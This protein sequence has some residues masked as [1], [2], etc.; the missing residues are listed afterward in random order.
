M[1]DIETILSYQTE[2]LSDFNVNAIQ[3]L[4]ELIG[5]KKVNFILASSLEATGSSNDLLINIVKECKGN[6]YLCGGGAS[7]YFLPAKFDKHNIQVE[8]QNF[9]HPAYDQKPKSKFL[10][11][12]SII[13]VVMNIGW[14]GAF[15]LLHNEIMV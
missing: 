5:I 1:D 13:D 7:E 8:Y 9:K 15:D 12:L 14:S 6:A 3:K 10:A 4:C 2:S 11:G